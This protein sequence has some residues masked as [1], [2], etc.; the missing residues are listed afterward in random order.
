MTTED[1]DYDYDYESLGGNST[2]TQNAI[3]GALAGIGEHC[4]MYP[5]DSIKTRVQVGQTWKDA[6]VTSS[7]LKH[8]LH[9][10]RQLWK[11]VYS[12]VMGAGPAHAL[13]FTTYEVCKL[14]FYRLLQQG[15]WVRDQN[16]QLLLA[17]SSAGVCATLS[18]DFMMTPFDVVK[19]RMQL[20]D[21]VYRSVRECA[22]K[23]Y[24]KEGIMAFYISLPTTLSMSIPFQ[25]IQFT[26]YERCLYLLNANSQYDPQSHVVAGAVAGIMASSVTTPLDVVKTLLQTRG[27]STDARIRNCSGFSE[28]FKIIYSQYGYQGFFRGFK[29]RI[30]THMPATAISWSVYE[31]FKW[32]LSRNN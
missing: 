15:S 14:R 9:S 17:T 8:W 19:Q 31:Y 24:A 25:T 26:T 32:F 27:S 11:G 13:H 29:P 2:T 12:V 1:C 10:N 28:A 4:L 20:K 22:R 16:L 3:A 23:V 30:L 18:H 21:S 6:L 5:I 7:S